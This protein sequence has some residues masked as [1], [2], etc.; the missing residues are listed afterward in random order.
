ME[1]AKQVEEKGLRLEEMAGKW[2]QVVWVKDAAREGSILCCVS[3]REESNRREWKA[4]DA[5]RTEAI[6]EAQRRLRNNG[7]FLR[8]AL[9]KAREKES[10]QAQ[11]K[12]ISDS[13]QAMRGEREGDCKEETGKGRGRLIPTRIG[14]KKGEERNRSSDGQRRLQSSRRR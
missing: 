1:E 5:L 6:E 13:Y 14:E 12:E 11:P 10:I 4:I 8:A 7:R 3:L 2:I 9:Q